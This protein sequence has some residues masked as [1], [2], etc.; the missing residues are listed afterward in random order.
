MNGGFPQQA[1]QNN[2]R[3]YFNAPSRSTSGRL[4]RGLSSTF[5][6]HWSQP[7]L[8]YNS[9]LPVEQQFL[10]NAI[11]FETS[12]LQSAEVKKNV[13]LQLNR[14]SND[15]AVRVATALG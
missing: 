3:G 12:H 5:D 11:R 2:G 10:I 1:D 8:F 6:D 13:L 9:L 14:I 15:I 7:R 4:V